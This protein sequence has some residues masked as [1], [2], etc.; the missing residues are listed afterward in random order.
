[1]L[2]CSYHLPRT[3]SVTTPLTITTIQALWPTGQIRLQDRR[4]LTPPACTLDIAG[5]QKSRNWQTGA[6]YW[7]NCRPVPTSS[8]L[9]L[10]RFVRQILLGEMTVHCRF[11]PQTIPR[12]FNPPPTD[13][14]IELTVMAA[15]PFQLMYTF[16]CAGLIGGVI[17]IARLCRAVS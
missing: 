17:C 6:R 5:S 8:S 10:R 4:V 14:I 13:P 2:G 9:D 7:N 11:I 3:A 12:H 16:L 15:L 1:M